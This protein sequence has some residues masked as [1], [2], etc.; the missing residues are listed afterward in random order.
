M[1]TGVP[2]P[3]YTYFRCRRSGES[4][5][6]S[7]MSPSIPTGSLKHR[8]A[9]SLVLYGLCNNWIGEDTTLVEASSGSTAVSEAYFAGLL[10]L[11][12]HRRDAEDDRSGEVRAD[13]VLRRP[14]PPGRRSRI[15]STP[16]PRSWRPSS[17]GHYL[18]QFTYAERATDWRGNNNIAESMF[19]QLRAG[20]APGA[21]T[22][23]WSAP[24]PAAPA[25]RSA[26]TCDSKKL[27]TQFCI[28]D[29]EALRS[30]RLAAGRPP[31]APP[32][33]D[34]G[35]RPTSGRAQLRARAS[36]TG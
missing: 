16:W 20:A 17:G 7:R 2:T 12:V 5:F 10:G 27:P 6:I 21:R 36:S 29:P 14:L 23:W 8:L 30:H 15:R 3:T 24:E 18:D 33:P 32:A 25:P 34:R 31:S 4:G 28:V 1:P 35:H 19:A 13:R 22:G 9:R 11:P 26:A